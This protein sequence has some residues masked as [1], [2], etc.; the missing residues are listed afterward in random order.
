MQKK[1]MIILSLILLLSM[2]SQATMVFA[3]TDKSLSIYKTEAEVTDNTGY[4]DYT[5]DLKSD[6]TD[7]KDNKRNNKKSNGFIGNTK[8]RLDGKYD[9]IGNKESNYANLINDAL[10]KKTGADISMINTGT[11][12][13]SIEKGNI[14]ESDVSVSLMFG[15]DI[16]TKKLTGKQIKEVLEK[17]VEIYPET[18]SYFIRPGG[19]KYTINPNRKKGDRIRSLKIGNK[20]VDMSKKYIVAVNNYME[21]DYSQLYKA[22][23]IK[24]YGSID[25]TV[26]D[27]IKNKTSI[28]YKADGRITIKKIVPQNN[29]KKIRELINSIDKLTYDKTDE[30]TKKVNEAVKIYNSL[31]DKDKKK[32]K[33]SEKLIKIV[34]ELNKKAENTEGD[35]RNLK[36]SNTSESSR[37]SFTSNK[38][39]GEKTPKTG[40]TAIMVPSVMLIS[41]AMGLYL[42][43]KKND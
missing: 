31:S 15:T 32:V 41:S 39:S 30:N 17:G 38:K 9:V 34:K 20:S 21:S 2:V 29:D 19:F 28:N 1:R 43:K 33:N 12:I 11:I 14:R 3:D 22:D 26:I 40:D 4:E 10:L 36:K 16:V 23:T 35:K 8:H 5:Q 13:A 42:L 6:K 25:K 24:N 7:D 18:S 37:T 27:F